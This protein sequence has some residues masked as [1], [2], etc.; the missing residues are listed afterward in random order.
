[1]FSSTYFTASYFSFSVVEWARGTDAKWLPLCSRTHFSD[2]LLLS[3]NNLQSS[4]LHCGTPSLC[5]SCAIFVQYTRS[6][7]V[8]KKTVVLL[9]SVA[10]EGD[11]NTVRKD[12]FS[13]SLEA[14]SS[15]DDF[16]KVRSRTRSFSFFWEKGCGASSTI[17]TSS[18]ASR[19]STLKKSSSLMP[20][21]SPRTG[22][23]ISSQ[24]AIGRR[25]DSRSGYLRLL[26]FFC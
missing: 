5:R 4:G 6:F 24:W 10:V 11:T 12:V 7:S 9:T 16:D 26:L 21:S 13:F 19:S 20:V 17:T 14:N 23:G 25:T 15:A 1:M 8:E 2:H 3:I 22:T 18:S